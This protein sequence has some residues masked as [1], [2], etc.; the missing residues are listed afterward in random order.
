MAKESSDDEAGGGTADSNR[1]HDEAISASSAGEAVTSQSTAPAAAEQDNTSADVSTT[2]S[3]S[4]KNTLGINSTLGLHFLR[5]H[6]H[7][8]PH[9][10]H[11]DH[12]HG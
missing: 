8:T 10:A 12:V 1:L 2:S 9:S 7:R 3:I 6:L 4:S 11:F 5:T